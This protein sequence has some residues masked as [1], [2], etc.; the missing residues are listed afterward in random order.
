M[1]S[2]DAAT[3]R[4]H[5]AA[6]RSPT[7]RRRPSG[8]CRAAV[9]YTQIVTISTDNIFELNYFRGSVGAQWTF[10][11]DARRKSRR[12]SRPGVHRPH[13]DPMIPHTLVLTGARRPQR[14]QR[15]LVLGQTL[16]TRSRNS[17]FQPARQGPPRRA[18]SRLATVSRRKLGA[19][20]T[21]R[22]P[23]RGRSR[24]LSRAARPRGRRVHD[25]LAAAD[26]TAAYR[27]LGYRRAIVSMSSVKSSTIALVN[28]GRVSDR[29]AR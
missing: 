12:I 21:R 25:P 15:L 7:S 10:L 6:T 18:F 29:A 24:S 8:R 17:V 13:H 16:G 28:V 14:L 11:S 4:S 23:P 9:A 2:S 26:R 1:L 22:A 19:L 20:R 3:V 27:A 5:G